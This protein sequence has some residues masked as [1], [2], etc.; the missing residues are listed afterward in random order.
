MK[1]IR[2]LGAMALASCVMLTGCDKKKEQPSPEPAPAV[3]DPTITVEGFP[4]KAVVGQ[5]IDLDEVVTVT[6]AETFSVSVSEEEASVSGHVVKLLKAG[7]VSLTLTAGATSK[8]CSVEVI[9]STRD[10]FA[11]YVEGVGNEYG[12]MVYEQD[13]VDDKGTEDEQDD[14]WD[15]VLADQIFHAEN[16]VLMT[17]TWDQDEDKNPIPGGYLQ[18]SE[19]DGVAYAYYLKGTDVEIIQPAP[20]YILGDI[21]SDIGLDF[22]TMS[23]YY[24]EQYEEEVFFLEGEE[25]MAFA[26][27]SLLFFDGQISLTI[28]DFDVDY[29]EFTIID[30]DKDTEELEAVL[31]CYAYFNYNGYYYLWSI[32]DIFVAGTEVPALDA[33]CV[34]ENG[35]ASKDYYNEFLPNVGEDAKLPGYIP[36][37]DGLFNEG[38]LIVSYGWANDAGQAIA[39]PSDATSF[40]GGTLPSSTSYYIFGENSVWEVIPG[41]TMA[42]VQGKMKSGGKLYD[43]YIEGDDVTRLEDTESLSLY[44]SAFSFAGLRA[45]STYAVGNIVY[46]KS[47]TIHDND[48]PDDTSDDLI[49]YSLMFAAGKAHG[50][51]DT[52]V[53][54]VSNLG[55]LANA[56]AA[57]AQQWH[58]DLEEFFQVSMTVIPARGSVAFEI[59]FGWAT[60]QNYVISVE[61]GLTPAWETVVADFETAYAPAAV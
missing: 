25:A 8:S 28:G 2:L 29:I 49:G 9:E 19:T 52:I 16:Y 34:P 4:E 61:A 56:I 40:F 32:N 48:T 13:V 38:Q 15:W 42:A 23:N 27:N 17:N 20:A 35:Y 5:E 51:I 46:D 10:L 37:A 21:N 55:L 26:E 53:E 14:E 41:E 7:S 39:Q 22:S 47:V 36:S 59:S 45:A 54:N 33:Y 6:G 50:V 1:K 24:D 58:E 44:E 31:E 30:G 12:V 57:Y 60:N 11:S 43:I 18:F 3:V